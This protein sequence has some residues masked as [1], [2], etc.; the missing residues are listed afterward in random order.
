MVGI[1]PVEIPPYVDRPQLVTRSGKHRLDL[2]EFDRWAE[3]LQTDATRVL[4][5]NLSQFLHDRATIVM[6]DGVIPLD[7]QVRIEISRFDF[8]ES[9]EAFL[10]AQWTIVGIEDGAILVRRTSRFRHPGDSQDYASLVS[11]M[12][13]NLEAFSQEITEALKAHL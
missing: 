2:S 13:Q 9:G 7:Y 5:E 6:W 11:A 12:S 1:G 4:V 3:P 10:A 8:E